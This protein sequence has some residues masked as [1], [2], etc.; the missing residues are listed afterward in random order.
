MAPHLSGHVS[1]AFSSRSPIVSAT[2]HGRWM[3]CKRLADGVQMQSTPKQATKRL[4]ERR[5]NRVSVHTGHVDIRDACTDSLQ[6][7]TCSSRSLEQLGR[8]LDAGLD[9]SL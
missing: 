7:C 4:Q 9:H 2:L 8:K 3:C 6:G 1:S 5:H